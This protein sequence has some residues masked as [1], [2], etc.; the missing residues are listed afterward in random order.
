LGH[1]EYAP[2]LQNLLLK[3]IITGFSFQVKTGLTDAMTGLSEE[4]EE[5]IQEYKTNAEE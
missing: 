5:E 3:A 4:L 1:P 2:V